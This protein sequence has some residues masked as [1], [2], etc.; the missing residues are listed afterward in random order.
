MQF[1][2]TA[3]P[4]QNWNVILISGPVANKMR[5]FSRWSH[6]DS[7]RNNNNNASKELFFSNLLPQTPPRHRSRSHRRVRPA[8][9]SPPG[10]TTRHRAARCSSR[11]RPVECCH[12][13]GHRVRPGEAAVGPGFSS[14]SP[15]PAPAAAAATAAASTVP[16][17]RTRASRRRRRPVRPRRPFCKNYIL[18]SCAYSDCPD[19][20]KLTVF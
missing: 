20:S 6:S 11:R 15:R 9:R 16:T 7:Y 13:R 1:P 4:L 18:L 10:T 19:F 2:S 3:S 8:V 5:S 14:A 12:R 17:A